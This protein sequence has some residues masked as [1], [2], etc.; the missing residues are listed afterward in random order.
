MLTRLSI[1]NYALIDEL[2]IDFS[3]GLNIVTGETGAGKS[4]ILGGLSLILGNR[5]D[6]T[7]LRDNTKKCI[8]EGI[9]NIESYGFKS[10]FEN[11]DLDY[12]N[13]SI[14]RREITPSGNSRAFIN[15][16]PVN[17]KVMSELSKKL[18]DIHSQHQNLELTTRRFQLGLVDMVANNQEILAN[19]KSLYSG[20]I[21]KSKLLSE[22]KEKAEKERTDLDYYEFQLK[23]LDEANLVEENE[24]ETLEAEMEK[25]SHSEEIKSVLT[26]VG[27]L[28]ENEQ[29]AILGMLKEGN[30]QLR[31][32]VEYMKEVAVLSERMASVYLELQDIAG[33]ITTQADAID[34]NPGR[35]EQIT[36]RLD[37]IFSLQ[38]K[39]HVNSVADLI[40]VRSL[41]RERIS[42]IVDYDYQIAN[43]EKEITEIKKQV[44]ETASEISK[45]RLAI[46]P[47]IEKR[48]VEILQQL[49]MPKSRFK[50][51]HSRL[52]ECGD[53]GADSVGFLFSANKDTEPAE[54]S[55][56]A[57]G[58]ETS[59]LMLAIKS[60]ITDTKSL[61]TIIFDEI[62]SGVS[63]EIAIKMGEILR[64]FS[65]SIQ[66]I[67]ITH[68]PQIAGKGDHHFMVFKYDNERGTFTSIK[69]LSHNERIEELAK[70]VSGDNPTEN[71]IQTA[72]ELLN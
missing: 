15:D 34:F 41:I 71:A 69:K 14:F 10:F 60:L 53:S 26:K 42:G 51:E 50:V 12:E 9:F 65:K 59:R 52:Q 45:K 57:S 13:Q 16:T 67:N 43:L 20:F 68:L 28:L 64:K 47:V 5:A 54:I 27:Q 37:L 35:L 19:Y 29:V 4:I 46:F 33:E 1:N 48:V 40:N 11:N 6:T 18:I 30:S 17:L 72:R 49:G 66:V 56:I 70:M 8:V 32:I 24:Q 38:Q 62:D 21:K 3:S 23:Q 39:H 25:L 61:P 22:L 58:G 63:G 7:S 31:K 44:E 55:K 36:Q 2:A